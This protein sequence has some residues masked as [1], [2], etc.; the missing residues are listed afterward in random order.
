[1][2]LPVEKMFAFARYLSWAD[3]QSG[4]FEAEMGNQPNPS[5]AGAC[6]EHEWRWFG[7]MCYW[8]A[9]LDVV[10]EAWD[11]L[12]FIDP[13]INRLLAH[14]MDY[15]RLLHRYRNAV[16]HYQE[17][18]LSPKI[19][20]LMETGAVHVYWVRALHDEMV[21]FF[22]EY[23]AGLVVTDEQRSELRESIQSIVNWYPCCETRVADSLERTLARARQ[24]LSEHGDDGSEERAELESSLES[25]E[26]LL[27]ESRRKWTTLRTEILRQAGIE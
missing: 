12:H 21:R 23:L 15:R 16:C 6:R 2:T 27:R 3:L 18:V 24:M 1:M 4:L 22:K 9:S 14:P 13:V 11:E 19:I 25:A 8:Y 10:I 20:E 26:A 5:D 17:S 7:L